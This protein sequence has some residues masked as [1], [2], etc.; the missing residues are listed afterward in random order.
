MYS[1]YVLYD[2][3][4]T[5]R[6]AYTSSDMLFYKRQLI[7]CDECSA[8]SSGQGGFDELLKLNP[9][10]VG[11]VDI[12]D[13]NI[14]YPIMQGSDDLEYASKDF[15]GEGSLSGSI[16]LSAENSSDFSDSYN[17]VFGHHMKNGAMFGELENFT[18]EDF[19][20]RH[21]SGTLQT[22]AGNYKLRI[23]ACVLTDAYDSMIYKK[24]DGAAESLNGLI[25]YISGSAAVCDS[26]YLSVHAPEKITVFSTCADALTNGRAVVFADTIPCGTAVMSADNTEK[27]TVLT[28]VGHAAPNGQGHLAFLDLLCM[29]LTLLVLL[30]LFRVRCKYG[31]I[32]YTNERLKEINAYILCTEE[33]GETPCK[34]AYKVRNELKAF[35]MRMKPGILI[36]TFFAALS[37]AVFFLTQDITMPLVMSDDQTWLMVVIFTLSLLTDVVCFRGNVHFVRLV[38]SYRVAPPLL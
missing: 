29:I 17:L 10:V 26:K 20:Y 36:E 34:A 6:S 33:N 19:F 7:G 30:P 32:S 18:D 3:F 14:N 38:K 13:T 35:R 21:L 25:T 11:W 8:F 22:P 9:D 23:F 27:A 12:A 31:Q 16:Y 1:G 37:A 24:Y 4:C 28:A 5:N 15:K 2:V